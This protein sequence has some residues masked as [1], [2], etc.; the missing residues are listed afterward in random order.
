MFVRKCGRNWRVAKST[1]I[2]YKLAQIKK[3]CPLVPAGLITLLAARGYWLVDRVTLICI[4]VLDALFRQNPGGGGG[5]DIFLFSSKQIIRCLGP[6]TAFQRLQGTR[7]RLG[8][9]RLGPARLARGSPGP[10]G[11]R[12]CRLLVIAPPVGAHGPVAQCPRVPAAT[13][14]MSLKTCYT[15]L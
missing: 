14:R 5:G 8:V 6:L 15:V 12:A 4:V 3:I 1:F 11:G 9:P 10:I 13:D 7:S 2:D